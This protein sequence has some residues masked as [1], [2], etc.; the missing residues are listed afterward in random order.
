KQHTTLIRDIVSLLG[1]LATQ[2][3]ARTNTGYMHKTALKNA[4]RTF[5]LLED[6]YASF[7]YALSREAGLIAPQG[8]KQNYALTTKGDE[9]LQLGTREQ[10]ETLYLA[11]RNGTM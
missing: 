5:S 6:R 9:W 11:W 10:Q 3:A 4:A 8:E 7:V 2:E 1:F